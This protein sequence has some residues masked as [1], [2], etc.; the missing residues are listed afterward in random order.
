MAFPS[1]VEAACR[2][3]PLAAGL[4]RFVL[5]SALWLLAF[6]ALPVVLLGWQPYSVLSGSMAPAIR[7]GDV[8]LYSAV[9]TEVPTGAVVVFADPAGERGIL[10]HRVVER[11]G[12]GGYRTKGDANPTPDSAVI[13]HDD[14]RGMGRLL[15][16]LAGVPALWAGDERLGALSVLVA[17]LALLMAWTPRGA[18]AGPPLVASSPYR[19]PPW[20]ATSVRTR[21]PVRW[22]GAATLVV[23]TAMLL[24]LTGLSG[25][26]FA[27]TTSST[28]ETTAGTLHTPP[29][30]AGEIVCESNSPAVDL[31]W[32]QP[33]ETITSGYEIHR[34]TDGGAPVLLTTITDR[35]VTSYRDATVQSSTTYDYTIRSVHRSWYSPDSGV[36]ILA[37][38]L[39]CL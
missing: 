28:A 6:V 5:A 27:A 15:V 8:V 1:P 31:S 10:T 9:P 35:T 20:C 11:D 2:A 12:H 3:Q 23:G 36:V 21:T 26:G 32:S 19:T 18:S 16:P 33:G 39:L 7:P 4:R 37:T 24:W 25:A 34:A 29:D 13:A 14:I 17:V 38:E 30:F 22:P